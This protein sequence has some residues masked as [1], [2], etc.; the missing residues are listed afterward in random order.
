M[1]RSVAED[2]QDH[3][4]VP[5][6]SKADFSE[7]F[8]NGDSLRVQWAGWDPSFVKRNLNGA[9]NANLWVVAWNSDTSSF[10][11]YLSGKHGNRELLDDILMVSR[12]SGDPRLD[13]G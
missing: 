8:Y 13:Q 9:N 4:L 2:F 7:T 6:G 5:D 12:D 1:V 3:W 10:S 11:R